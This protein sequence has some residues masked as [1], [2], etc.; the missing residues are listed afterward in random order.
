MIYWMTREQRVEDNWC[1]LY[2]QQFAAEKGAQLRVIF[3]LVPKFLEATERH[4]SFMLTGLREV[5]SSLRELCIPFE[6]LAG[7]SWETLPPYVEQHA[8]GAV[9]TCFGPLRI[10]KD[11][12]KKV[13]TALQP[14]GVPLIQVDGHNIVPVWAAS[15][16][17]EYAARTIRPKIT[18]LLPQYLT[19]F[20]K[21]AAQPPAIAGPLPAPVD[22]VALD[23]TLQIDRRVKACP[24]IA[25]GAAAAHDTLHEF[26]RARLHNFSTE[27][28]D[29]LAKQISGLSPYLHFGQIAL[30]RAVLEV[31]RYRERMREDVASF[32]EEIFVRRELSDN[33]SVSTRKE[34][35]HA[36]DRCTPYSLPAC[37]LLHRAAVSTTFC[38][39]KSL[40]RILGLARPWL[41][42]PL[43]PVLT[44]T[45]SASS[46]AA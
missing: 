17:Q 32:V 25:P 23:V 42:I 41:R 27:R 10:T 45:P 46:K 4:Y 40:A 31:N 2:A 3:C 19:E 6:V 20:P 39:I 44:C 24:H 22:W 13:S 26:I 18:R 33:Q 36:S 11:W 15:D 1:L 34:E 8:A 16:K 28:N 21:V 9:V 43:I 7:F 30:Q 5:E 12:N 37:C 29:P 35:L 38:M 14:L